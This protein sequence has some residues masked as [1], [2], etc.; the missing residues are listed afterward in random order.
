MLY[1]IIYAGMINSLLKIVII[2]FVSYGYAD[3]LLEFEVTFNAENFRWADLEL[4]TFLTHV[5]VSFIAYLFLWMA[6]ALQSWAFF[7]P[8]LLSTPISFVWYVGSAEVNHVFPFVGI[9]FVDWNL[10]YIVLVVAS[11]LWISQILAFGYYVFQS[12]DNVLTSDANLFWTPRYNG[13]FLE[14]HILLNRKTDITGCYER[15]QTSDPYKLRN[16]AKDSHIFI[17]STMYHENEVEMKQMLKSIN[18]VATASGT[19]SA[20]HHKYESHIFFDNALSGEHL[21]QWVM[22]LLGL[23]T[24]TL[25]IQPANVTKLF[26]PYG[27]QLKYTLRGNMP[28][29]IHLKDNSKVKNKKRWSQV[30]YMNYVLNYRI[31]YSAIPKDKAFILTTDADIDFTSDDVVALLDFLARDDGVGAVC[32]RT[33]P[34]GSGPVVWYQIFDYAVGH[35]F[36]KAAEHVLGCV[37]CCPGCFSAFRVSAIEEVLSTY[38]SNAEN[39]FDFLTKDM[40]EDR[41]LCTLLIQA[42]W[43]LEYAAVSQDSTFCPETFDEFYK[44]RRRWIPSTV[45]NLALVISSYDKITANNDSISIMFILYQFLLVFSTLI[46]PATVI[47][48]IVTGLT[49]LDENLDDVALIVVLCVISVLYGVICVY[50]TE[51]TQIDVAKLLTIIFAIIMG[52]VVSGILTD[53]ISS[54][55]EGDPLDRSSRNGTNTF[56]FPVDVTSVYLGIFSATFIVAGIVHFNEFMCLFHFIWY[57]LCLPSGYLF[58]TIYSA[59]NINN[60][61]WGTREG[62]SP[63]SGG[64]SDTWLDYFLGK[65]HTFLGFFWKC[66]GWKPR[67]KAEEP[68][69]PPPAKKEHIVSGLIPEPRLSKDVEDWLTRIECEVSRLFTIYSNLCRGRKLLQFYCKL[70]MFSPQLF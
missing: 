26:T 50:A 10:R 62:A 28:F 18:R 20:E 65:W 6:C 36:Q 68:P 35:W 8:M 24:D 19:E 41:W 21:S 11:L 59:S 38:S 5:I 43:R 53:T 39:G 16:I 17:C 46:S 60:R 55:I 14:Q 67:S 12:S 23:L 9:Y 57:L 40:G 61:S 33:H 7:I 34:L 2:P 47:L 13:V 37:L 64:K 32:A 42:G 63:K 22:Q 44:Q 56:R 25:G 54:A 27:M 70:R 66:I 15:Q 3:L 51:K 48:I 4:S 52:V 45:A 49:A 29:Y 58:L 69:P 1:V 31:K 30:M